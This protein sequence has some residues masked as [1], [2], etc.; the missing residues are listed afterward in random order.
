[1]LLLLIEKLQQ[2]ATEAK[3]DLENTSFLLSLSGGMDSTT[4]GA[5][6]L[7]LKNKYKFKLGF[8]HI[9]H[10]AHIMSEPVEN[11]CSQFSHDNN[12]VF[13]CHKLFIDPELILSTAASITAFFIAAPVN[14]K[15]GV[16]TKSIPAMIAA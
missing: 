8:I 11:F 9:N 6:L 12:V 3:V 15:A 16:A 2:Y 13:Y 5:L 1:M 7:E 14:K 4:M 10:S